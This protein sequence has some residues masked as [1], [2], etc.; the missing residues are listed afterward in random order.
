VNPAGL[1]ATIRRHADVRG[2][3]DLDIVGQRTG[4]SGKAVRE[5]REGLGKP[6]TRK[7]VGRVRER[8]GKLKSSARAGKLKS[9]AR[10]GK[11]FRIGVVPS[12]DGPTKAAPVKRE[13]AEVPGSKAGC[14]G[15][16]CTGKTRP[17]LETAEVLKPYFSPAGIEGVFKRLKSEPG[18]RPFL[19]GSERRTG[20]RVNISCPARQFANC[21][22][23]KLKAAGVSG[24]W[25]TVG[26]RMETRKTA[27]PAA[28]ANGMDANAPI[29]TAA[30]PIAAVRAYF[31]AMGMDPGPE[32]RKVKPVPPR[33]R[34]GKLAGGWWRDGRGFQG[35][36]SGPQ[37]SPG[38]SPAA[39]GAASWRGAGA[40]T[41]EV[42]A[43]MTTA[44]ASGT[45]SGG[46]ED[47]PEA[48]RCRP[49]CDWRR[50]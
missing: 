38:P 11:R 20:A 17:G 8:T 26:N 6:R 44:E 9:S 34:D 5:L 35:G 22:R 7:G 36:P 40:V 31:K 3:S 39:A 28:K 42:L 46:G 25:A 10:A 41:A 43:A 37:S 2:R 19:S 45:A 23:R 29:E 18:S 24:S 30:T 50:F 15:V 14:P 32:T 48:L 47:G 13:R 1:P 12:G 4:K 27:A 33:K 21:F 16:S 49:G